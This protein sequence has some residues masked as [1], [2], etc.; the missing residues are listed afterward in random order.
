VSM[1]LQP[2]HCLYSSCASSG[3]ASHLWYLKHVCASSSRAKLP[4]YCSEAV[5]DNESISFS[6]IHLEHHGNDVV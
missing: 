1:V 2:L 5:E 6:L 3:R 4:M